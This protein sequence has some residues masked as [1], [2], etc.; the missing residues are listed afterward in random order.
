[1]YVKCQ[2]FIEKAYPCVVKTYTKNKTI[3]LYTYDGVKSNYLSYER[4]WMRIINYLTSMPDFNL[5]F[6]MC[7]IICKNIENWKYQN[8]LDELWVCKKMMK[9]L[10][11]LETQIA[12][13]I[14]V[15]II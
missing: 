1:M 3:I 12:Q 9:G 5:E 4:H 6:D 15:N 10:E 13:F 14:D 8:D 7:I 11:T 2:Y